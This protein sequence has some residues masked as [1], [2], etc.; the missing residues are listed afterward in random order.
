MIIIIIT[1][2]ITIP[3]FGSSFLGI[4]NIFGLYL[5]YCASFVTE[6]WVFKPAR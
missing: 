5:C 4:F 2:I 6:K 3:V 1:I